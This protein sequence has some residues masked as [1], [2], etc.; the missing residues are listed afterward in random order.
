MANPS[1][2]PEGLIPE[3]IRLVEQLRSCAL[4]WRAIAEDWKKVIDVPTLYDGQIRG[5]ALIEQAADALCAMAEARH[6]PTPTCG[7]CQHNR[8]EQFCHKRVGRPFGWRNEQLAFAWVITYLTHR[9]RA[10]Q[11]VRDAA[12]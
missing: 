5:A 10:R 8:G 3:Q 1:P 2:R 12:L 9:A 11:G 7:N 6:A 4:E